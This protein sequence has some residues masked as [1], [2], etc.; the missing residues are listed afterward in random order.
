[1][2]GTPTKGWTLAVKKHPGVQIAVVKGPH[3][4]Q[5]AEKE[6]IQR[7]Y[8]RLIHDAS[9]ERGPGAKATPGNDVSDAP[10]VRALS[11]LLLITSDQDF[12]SLCRHLDVV[13]VKTVV[14]GRSGRAT[15]LFDA[16]ALHLDWDTCVTLCS[17]NGGSAG[18]AAAAGAAAAVGGV[19]GVGTRGGRALGGVAGKADV[20]DRVRQW[21]ASCKSVD[22]NVVVGVAASGDGSLS[23]V[24]GVAAPV[25]APVVED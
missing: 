15:P 9:E 17:A 8:M 12:T 6:I 24:A 19:P 14:L 10:A 25:T 13:G 2:A 3:D 11:T 1:M 7:C 5:N 22:G 21:V 16:A 23:S 20:C 4:K 18:S